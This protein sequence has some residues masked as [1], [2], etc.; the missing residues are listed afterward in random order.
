MVL[1]SAFVAL[2]L[3]MALI[4]RVGGADAYPFAGQVGLFAGGNNPHGLVSFD[5][6][7]D[8][9]L[10][11]IAAN[12]GSSTLAVLLGNGDGTFGPPTSYPVGTTPKAVAIGDLNGDGLPDAVTAEQGSS[13]VS[14]LLGNG[15]GTF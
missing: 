14:V 3:S 7:G 6:N 12:A 1:Q 10:D 15:G 11:L 4:A 13:T 2:G 9:K 5:L 8:G